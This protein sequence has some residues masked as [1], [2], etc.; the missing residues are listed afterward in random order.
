VSRVANLSAIAITLAAWTAAVLHVLSVVD[1]TLEH[2]HVVSP[3]AL[4]YLVLIT[5]L[6]TGSLTYLSARYG[7][8]R[9][10]S[11]RKPASDAELD[12]FRMAMAPCPRRLRTGELTSV[13]WGRN[14][15]CLKAVNGQFRSLGEAVAASRETL[16]LVNA[17][18]ETTAAIL[19]GASPTPSQLVRGEPSVSLEV[20]RWKGRYSLAYRSRPASH[21][22]HP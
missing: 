17:G 19:L 7:Y 5:T 12:E 10:F 3:A 2:Q 21:P 6:V 20:A 14:L 13:R 18:R 16:S 11:A 15:M 9:R 4:S 1:L 8:A 22:A